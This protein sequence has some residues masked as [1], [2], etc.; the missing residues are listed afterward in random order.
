MLGSGSGSGEVRE[1]WDDLLTQRSSDPGQRGEIPPRR[2]DVWTK[3]VCT[4]MR[5]EQKEEKPEC[6]IA[7]YGPR[8]CVISN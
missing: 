6:L 7:S 8:G 5:A 4:V 1:V 2:C 3:V